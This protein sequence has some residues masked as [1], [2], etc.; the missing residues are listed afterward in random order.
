M[1]YPRKGGRVD[2]ERT[3]RQMLSAIDAGVNYFDTAYVYG[4]GQSEAVLGRVL[5][6]PGRREKVLVA[7]KIPPY[8][9]FSRKDM[10]RILTTMLQRLRTDRVDFLLAHALSDFPSWERLKSLGYPGFLEQARRDG[11]IR[12]AGFSWHGNTAEFRKVVDDHP[13][14]FC[15]IQYNYLDE[16]NQAGREGLEHAAARGLG[17][18]VMEPLR[19]GMLVGRMPKEVAAVMAQA[20]VRRSPAAWALDWIWDHPG[21]STVLSGLNEESHIEEDIRLAG[22][23]APGMF[24]EADRRAV[25]G[26]R[27]AYG[28]LMRTGC[29]GCAYCMPCPFGVDIPKAFALQNTLHVFH[30]GQA[31]FQ[32]TIHTT[33]MGGGAPSKASQCRECGKCET[34]CPQHIPIRERLKEAD[35]EL[36]VKAMLPAARLLR[37]VMRRRDRKARAGA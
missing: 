11:R 14:D 1:R 7:D 13:W 22:E 30:D 24:T 4:M 23:S 36:T 21:V 18:V 16:R 31:R 32:Y 5:A 15:Q 12:F 27:E 8:I 28:R 29:T 20:E 17:V 33:G 25:A 35:R 10:D 19:G 6:E 3:R 26:I 37:I 9:V 2:E 34:R